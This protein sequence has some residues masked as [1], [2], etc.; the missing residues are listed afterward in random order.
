MDIGNTQAIGAL[1]L[2]LLLLTFGLDDENHLRIEVP[3]QGDGL[4]GI[5]VDKDRRRPA[6]LRHVHRMSDQ[7]LTGFLE[8]FLYWA[9][10]LVTCTG[11]S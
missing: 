2:H 3:G 9:G 6:G 10:V 5:G 7:C 11:A 4:Q 1:V 8:R